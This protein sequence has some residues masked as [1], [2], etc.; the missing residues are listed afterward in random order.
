MFSV[1]EAA[2][3]ASNIIINDILKLVKE[4]D[5]NTSELRVDADKIA[6]V[7]K[8]IKQKRISRTVGS[9]I[10]EA[11]FKHNVSPIAYIKENNLEIINDEETIRLAVLS[12]LVEYPEV[13]TDFIDGNTRAYNFLV[14]QSMHALANKADP[15]VVNNILQT[16]LE[17]SMRL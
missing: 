17:L 1:Q 15:T 8:L 2:S 3:E 13:I 14:G 16:E 12:V 6:E 9:Q 7:I 11:V 4:T 5:T 10:I